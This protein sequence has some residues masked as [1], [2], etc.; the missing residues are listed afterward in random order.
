MLDRPEPWCAGATVGGL[1]G[2]AGLIFPT[3]EWRSHEPRLANRT[4][5]RYR[6]YTACIGEL[7]KAPESTRRGFRITSVWGRPASESAPS[8]RG[9]EPAGGASLFYSLRCRRR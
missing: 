5:I 2:H 7:V 8:P 3:T 9:Y 1:S 4:G 6:G